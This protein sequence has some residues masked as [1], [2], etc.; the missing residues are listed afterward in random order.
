M[1]KS[2]L[3]KKRKFLRKRKRLFKK[4]KSVIIK[5]KFYKNKIQKKSTKK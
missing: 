1:K 5:G 4:K 3:K 2:R